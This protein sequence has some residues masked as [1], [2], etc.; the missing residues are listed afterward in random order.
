MKRVFAFL[1][2]AALVC[3]LLIFP[4]FATGTDGIPVATRP[5]ET[6]LEHS[7]TS[8]QSEELDESSIQLHDTFPGNGDVV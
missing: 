5:S 3:N 8:A 6:N 4:C 7:E 1:A 2:S